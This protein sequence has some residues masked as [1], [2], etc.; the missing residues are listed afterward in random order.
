ML[1]NTILESKSKAKV[2]NMVLLEFKLLSTYWPGYGKGIWELSVRNLLARVISELYFL[3]F[4][5]LFTYMCS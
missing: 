5:D 1:V 4:K 2:T 3:L